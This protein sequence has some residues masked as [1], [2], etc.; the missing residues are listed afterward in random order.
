MKQVINKIFLLILIGFCI[1]EVFAQE[2][3]SK[4]WDATK[5]KGTRQETYQI[6]NG[7]PNLL[8][9]WCLGKVQFT[10]GETLD[11]LY[12]KFSSYRDELIYFNKHIN[13]QIRIDKMNVSSFSFTD[14]F[15]QVHLF[16]KQ[17]FD[18][19]DKSERYFEVLDE[20][21]PNLLCYRKVNL[22]GTSPY[23]DQRGTLKNMAYLNE[24]LYYFYS[25]QKGYAAVKPN[26]TSLLSRFDK[27]SQRP[28]KKLLRKN[29]ILIHDEFSFV[30]A[31]QT[32]EKHGFKV[33]F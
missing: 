4:D 5:I 28:I 31:W 29:N 26:R 12:L 17:K 22:S 24:Y 11:S 30:M 27:E 25:P 20:S 10:N 32:I 2:G 1:Q 21:E 8:D 19:S 6:Y 14:E 3:P 9:N 15:G 33:M 23:Y 16:R 13:T 18:N 7:K